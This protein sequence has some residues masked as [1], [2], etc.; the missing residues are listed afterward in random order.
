MLGTA[1]LAKALNHRVNLFWF[2]PK[3]IGDR[4]PSRAY[5]AR[6]LC[7]STL[8]PLSAEYGFSLGVSGRE[9]LNNQP[10]F[11]MSRMDDGTP[12]NPKAQGAF[13]YFISLVNELQALPDE[14]SAERALHAFIVVRRRY[15]TEYTDGGDGTIASPAALLEAIT[16][17]MS[18]GSAGGSHAQAIAAGVMDAG[19]EPDRVESGRIND[20]SRHYPGDV[21]IWTSPE[22]ETVA[23]AIEVR[24]KPVSESDIHIFARR[25]QSEGLQDCGVLMVSLRQSP[26]DDAALHRWADGI[27]INLRL[28]HGWGPFVREALFWSEVGAN[29]AAALAATSA[30]ARLIEAEVSADALDRW[31]TL[32][33]SDVTN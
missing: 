32:T 33:S 29:E 12:V 9:P 11:R 4:D 3:H 26:L 28:W 24:D 30:R 31:D 10:F 8:V 27:G 18:E 1:M 21:C 20:P 25:C 22:K 5:S 17:F 16:V 15:V 14:A 23:R 19:L 6:T 13:D 2:K 7:V